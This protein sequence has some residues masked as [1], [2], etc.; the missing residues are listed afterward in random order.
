MMVLSC[1]DL[2]IDF[3]E[4]QRELSGPGQKLSC[5]LLIVTVAEMFHYCNE[6]TQWW[7]IIFYTQLT[8]MMEISFRWYHEHVSV[9]V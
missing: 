6:L 5:T 1:L 3:R 7:P 2:K 8:L 4:F 9:C